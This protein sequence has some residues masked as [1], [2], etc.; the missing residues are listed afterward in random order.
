MAEGKI[1]AGSGFALWIPWPRRPSR[2]GLTRNP[3][4][5]NRWL[6]GEKGLRR[7]G[8][9]RRGHGVRLLVLARRD[10]KFG[11]IERAGVVS[12]GKLNEGSDPCIDRRMGREQVGET[13]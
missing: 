11:Q 2:R 13:L 6:R 10:A 1:S 5:R 9:Y 3:A 8:L 4:K 12:A 7:R